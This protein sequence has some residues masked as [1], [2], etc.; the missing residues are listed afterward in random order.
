MTKT[1]RH[2]AKLTLRVE[3]KDLAKK[4]DLL[5]DETLN[6][7]TAELVQLKLKVNQEAIKELEKNLD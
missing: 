2:Q 3:L 1:E 4:L 6:F 5:P 7:L